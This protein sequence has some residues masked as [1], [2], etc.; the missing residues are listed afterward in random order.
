METTRLFS[1]LGPGERISL[2]RLGTEHLKDTGRPLKVAVDHSIWAFQNQAASGGTNP[3]L[4]T[5]FYRLCR[6]LQNNILAV[7]VFDGPNKPKFKRN[8][9]SG[10][11]PTYMLDDTKRLIRMFGFEV[12]QAP[13]EAEAECALL[14]KEG[15]VDVVFSEDVDTLM[16]GSRKTIRNWGPE[17]PKGK[18]V[19]TH[20]TMYDLSD[21]KRDVGL[22]PD[23]MVLVAL[24]SGGDYVPAGLE[25][26]GIKTGVQAAKAGFGDRLARITV[27]D[28][29]AQA[30]WKDELLQ[31][32][33]TNKS[34]YFSRKQ[35]SMKFRDTFPEQALLDYYF[36]P[37]VS[38]PG[39]AKLVDLQNRLLERL[40][41]VRGIREFASYNFDWQ[42][43]DGAEK[44]IR[45]FSQPLLTW[46][47][48]NLDTSP[49]LI[50]KI[51]SRRSHSSVDGMPELRISVLPGD[52]VSEID[53]EAEPT[54]VTIGGL[55]TDKDLEA[56]MG[57]EDAEELG[58]PKIVWDPFLAERYWIP[59]YLLGI[60]GAKL[61]EQFNTAKVKKGK[62]KKTS[63]GAKDK[64][65]GGIEKFLT[66]SKSV[67]KKPT[68]HVRGSTIVEPEPISPEPPAATK[69][70]KRPPVVVQPQSPPRATATSRSK[71]RQA[72]I[73]APVTKS[74][75]TGARCKSAAESDKPTIT[76]AVP[77]EEPTTRRAQPVPSEII[78]EN[79]KHAYSVAESSQ[80]AGSSVKPRATKNSD[81]TDFFTQSKRKSSKKDKLSSSLPD[82]IAVPE[83]SYPVRC[84]TTPVYEHTVPQ[85]VSRSTV[86]HANEKRT[87][88]RS[89]PVNNVVD[90]LSSP[91]SEYHTA[92]SS[93]P[94]SP[95][96]YN[97]PDS[98][99]KNSKS[100]QQLPTEAA[101][102]ILSKSTS[103]TISLD[104]TPA[105]SSTYGSR[106]EKHRT[107][108]VTNIISLISDS[109]G[110]SPSP[111]AAPSTRKLNRMLD[112]TPT[113]EKAAKPLA[114]K[115]KSSDKQ[116]SSRPKEEENSRKNVRIRE[117]LAGFWADLDE[118]SP[119]I[120]SSGKVW[121][122]VE[123]L[124][125]TEDD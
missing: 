48:R 63:E 83:H 92:Q 60:Q 16:F 95:L 43:R 17:N 11:M 101:P 59:E 94:S 96:A 119:S 27:G 50:E 66:V 112:F 89:P 8:K 90:L 86:Q 104:S 39:S 111:I 88:A 25:R 118:E 87:R 18:G 62:T 73:A 53:L 15:I 38:K 79:T 114:P 54:D 22:T 91:L 97:N 29:E 70:V 68:K 61:I 72:T 44:F 69:R 52:V 71:T 113:K 106:I 98:S 81:I 31:E 20:V 67:S 103:V 51:H 37:V 107:P 28:T 34:K 99:T 36:T 12:H 3:A 1:E 75:R 46:K 23:G 78:E 19:P 121:R 93:P 85:P 82:L 5:L 109:E 21:I 74:A 108:I 124:D 49:E 110:D 47:L 58:K 10:N 41:D 76:K 56:E 2:S 42:G 13:G 4:R 45:V 7:F 123:V 33:R 32:I 77:V 55:S 105:E 125:C 100:S 116:S 26:C 120:T 84:S 102:S 57:G 65:Q 30:I 40:P 80:I 117:S 35:P 9:R 6:L 115:S 14:Q 122:S 24:M 64:D